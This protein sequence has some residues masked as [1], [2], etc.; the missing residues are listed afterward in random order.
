MHRKS[1]DQSW[2]QAGT[3]SATG[4]EDHPANTG[5]PTPPAQDKAA[6][7][8]SVSNSG[9]AEGLCLLWRKV[10]ESL[11]Y[12]YPA[13]P[14][15]TDNLLAEIEAEI[16][17]GAVP[18]PDANLPAGEDILRPAPGR[19]ENVRVALVLSPERQL[20]QSSERQVAVRQQVETADLHQEFSAQVGSSQAAE[21]IG[22]L[23]ED[24]LVA[25]GTV[26]ARMKSFH[27][28]ASC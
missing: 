25:P 22:A 15:P 9:A 26:A 7:D 17:A 10:V 27:G 6:E 23:L 12:A 13:A 18:D 4:G 1:T 2:E 14:E 16:A 24:D 28:L 11:V 3:S 21:Q 19:L 5:E 20:E 8:A